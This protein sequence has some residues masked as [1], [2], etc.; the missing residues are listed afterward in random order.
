MKKLLIGGAIGLSVAAGALLFAE[1]PMVNIGNRHPNLRA[2]Q[3]SIA[4]AYQDTERAQSANH[5]HLGGH[6][7]RAKALLMQADQ[8]LRAAAAYSNHKR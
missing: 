6:A 1:G 5:G 7:A 2:A 4:A 3:Q 8:E